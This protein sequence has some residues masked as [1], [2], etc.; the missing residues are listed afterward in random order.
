MGGPGGGGGQVLRGVPTLLLYP[1]GSRPPW[2]Y[3]CPLQA[4]NFTAAGWGTVPWCLGDGLFPSSRCILCFESCG[5]CRLRH[6]LFISTL[7]G[8]LSPHA[9]AASAPG[10]HRPSDLWVC[11]SLPSKLRSSKVATLVQRAG[12]RTVPFLRRSLSQVQCRRGRVGPPK[13]RGEHPQRL[14]WGLTI[15]RRE[16][17]PLGGW[18]NSESSGQR[19]LMSCCSGVLGPAAVTQGF[20]RK[21]DV[22]P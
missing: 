22:L 9:S 16:Q 15:F 13:P 21:S 4:S 8:P 20:C 6:C 10:S 14:C 1:T 11:A 3:F 18:E 19:T 2:C 12:W 7:S 5:F 17:A